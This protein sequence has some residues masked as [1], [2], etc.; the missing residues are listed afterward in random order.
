MTDLAALVAERDDLAR[1]LAKAVEERD[2]A[3]EDEKR[4]EA[5]R[6]DRARE[7]AGEAGRGAIT[8]EEHEELLTAEDAA[9]EKGRKAR[10][11]AEA[12]VDALERELR[13]A[14]RAAFKAVE[15]EALAPARRLDVE[16]ARMEAE[17]RKARTG[18]AAILE[19]AEAVITEA[20]VELASYDPSARLS[21]QQEEVVRDLAAR[22]ARRDP[23]RPPAPTNPLMRRAFEA[24][25][26]RLE[27]EQ[28]QRE[29]A[30]EDMADWSPG[31]VPG[32]YKSG[33]RV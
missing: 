11:R 16:I 10:E 33:V 9:A 29:R 31:W 6:E 22:H 15:A 28:E 25:L 2:R 24:E 20:K 7:L 32:I 19:R 27:A 12:V 1:R 14:A 21:R 30:Y 17:L 8:S 23:Y 3:Q 26:A 13:E 18:R 4:V 5:C